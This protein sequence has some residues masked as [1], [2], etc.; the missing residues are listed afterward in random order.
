M[1]KISSSIQ[2]IYT[3]KQT[4][5][6]YVPDADEIKKLYQQN[7]GAFPYWS[8]IWPAAIG[9]CNF[10]EHNKHLLKNKTVLELAAGLGLPSLLAAQYCASI[11]MTD[12]LPEPVELMAA[13]IH[14]NHLS[15]ATA[16]I[17]NW[18]NIPESINTDILLMS[19]INYE[20]SVFEIVFGVIQRFINSGSTIMLSTPQRLMAKPFIERLLPWCSRQEEVVVERNNETIP[21]TILVLSKENSFI[22]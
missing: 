8:Q 16:H 21:A 5:S 11:T 19:D 14:Y 17:L 6:L 3:G 18:N 10:L 4:I 13:S 15:N 1:E 2:N 22:S 12:Y 9:L 20:P 7:A